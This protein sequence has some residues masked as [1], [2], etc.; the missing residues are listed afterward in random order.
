[1]HGVVKVINFV[2]VMSFNSRIVSYRPVFSDIR[3][4]YL[5]FLYHPD[6]VIPRFSNS[7]WIS[8]LAD[9]SDTYDEISKLNIHCKDRNVAG[10]RET[11]QI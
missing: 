2:R 1:M 8:E 10:I 7:S 3:S 5:H 4:D 9:I 11:V 6:P